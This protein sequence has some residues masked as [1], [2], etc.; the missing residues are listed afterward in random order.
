MASS[1]TVFSPSCVKAEHSRYYSEWTSTTLGQTPFF[2]SRIRSQD[3]P[4]KYQQSCGFRHAS[5][6]RTLA[7]PDC[8]RSAVASSPSSCPKSADLSSYPAWCRRGSWASE[9]NGARSCKKS[10]S[11]YQLDET[12]CMSRCVAARRMG[13]HSGNHLVLM[14]SKLA[15][16]TTEKQTRKMSVWG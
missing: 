8:T 11:S 5:G 4:R 13:T 10:G 15:G 1:K 2:H 7:S 3:P 16:L 12:L 6:L 9:D 14:F